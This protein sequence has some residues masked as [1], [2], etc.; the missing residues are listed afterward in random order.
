MLR[1]C[2]NKLDCLIF[3]MLFIKELKPTVN[4]VIPSALNYL[5]TSVLISPHHHHLLLLLLTITS[6]PS[7][8]KKNCQVEHYFPANF[9]CR[10]MKR[11]LSTVPGLVS[12]LF[13]LILIASLNFK[14]RT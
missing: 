2:H 6:G 5:F 8:G 1:K 10:V 12:R 9:L 14:L 11:Q 4:R 3:E 7:F 13:A